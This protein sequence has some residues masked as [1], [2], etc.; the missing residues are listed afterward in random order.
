MKRI[1][2]KTKKKS[3]V[4]SALQDHFRLEK[5][6]NWDS[7][8]EA[9]TKGKTDFFLTDDLKKLQS[10][11]DQS[12]QFKKNEER[13]ALASQGTQD[14]L[15][16][17]DFEKETIYYSPRWAD[18]I[19]M[20]ANSIPNT[21]DTWLARVHPEDVALLGAALEAHKQGG[22]EKFHAEYRLR[23]KNGYYRWMVSRGVGVTNDQGQVVRIVGSQSDIH[24]QRLFE[25]EL[26]HNALHDKMTGLPNRTLFMNALESSVQMLKRHPERKIAV[27]FIDIDRLKYVNDTLGHDT[28]DQLIIQFAK[29][30]ALCCREIDMVAR[31]GGDEFVILLSEIENFS[32]ATQFAARILEETSRPLSLK[33]H[34]VNPETSIGIA[35]SCTEY[36]CADDLR[37]SFSLCK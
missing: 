32:D 35:T 1:L 12:T 28:G 3:K 20:K 6:D 11:L 22:T 16:D 26:R 7:I 4:E 29:R 33:N 31:F 14:G 30:L 34:E 36:A 24:E 27:L 18:M 13:Y 25:S 15:W 37:V 5:E 10:L 21:P 23:H 9:L 8:S 19:G 2:H 17:W